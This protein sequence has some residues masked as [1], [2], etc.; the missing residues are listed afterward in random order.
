MRVVFACP[1]AERFTL[2]L[3]SCADA[4]PYENS[5]RFTVPAKPMMLVR[6]MMDWPVW[7]CLRVREAGSAV[8][9]KSGPVTFTRM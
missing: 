5:E 2:V 6:V 7:P 1:P 3:A 8:I 4:V 9:R